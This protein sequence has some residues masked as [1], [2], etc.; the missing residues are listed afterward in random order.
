MSNS[1]SESSIP[2]WLA[3]RPDAVVSPP[4]LTRAQDFPFDQLGWQDFERLC[5]RLARRD[6]DVE[7]CQLYGE[8]GDAQ[9]GIDLLAR[10]ANG[11]H[12][13]YQCK[14][15]RGL[16]AQRIER[17]VG[18]FLE[19]RWPASTDAFVICTHERMISK[20][21]ADA[22]HVQAQRLRSKGIRLLVWDSIELSAKL[23]RAPALAEEF[24]GPQWAEAMCGSRA[25]SYAPEPR[26]LLK[27]L[28]GIDTVLLRAIRD[29]NL[30]SP[31]ET[32][33]VYDTLLERHLADLRTTRRGLLS[34]L[35]EG[36]ELLADTLPRPDLHITV[37]PV[38]DRITFSFDDEHL[39]IP[40]PKLLWDCHCETA[41]PVA[42]AS[43]N[44]CPIHSAPTELGEKLTR[45]FTN[46][47]CSIRY[48]DTDVLWRS[49]QEFFPPS[50]DAFSFLEDLRASS[51][52]GKS[53]RSLLDLGCGTGFLGI[54]L[55]QEHP[56]LARLVFTDWLLTPLVFATINY[57]RNRDRVGP[58]QNVQF[59]L[60]PNLSWLEDASATPRLDAIV[61]NPPY[62]PVLD[63]FEELKISSTV[64][65][66][67]LLE[68]VISQGLDVARSIALSFSHIA[69]VEAEAAAS[70]ARRRLIPI[71]P[72]R[73]VPFRS[74]FAY[75][76]ENYMAE[77]VRQR[78]LIV[79]GNH[80]HPYWHY[81]RSYRIE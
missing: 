48:R 9:E 24:F 38:L 28:R 57:W 72:R 32:V 17:A 46:G 33:H 23:K 39:S 53:C 49:A 16:S 61:C 63:G 74:S 51:F 67:E 70:R 2:A 27:G 6:T 81:V 31:R 75:G 8:A 5:Y 29:H 12:R 59:C 68:V 56:S 73:K 43:H 40:Q 54:A 66:T 69:L 65:G 15:V 21:R 41:H 10:L 42:P 52:A 64:A 25:L 78:K 60:A 62:L 47:L 79:Q 50:V 26:A 22:L 34:F 45:L 77:L 7:H 14:R 71:G 44:E 11:R 30:L 19:G 3:A 1:D 36:R 58:I 4:V 35:D 13:A 37:S 55:A 80:R 76:T 20:A 18:K